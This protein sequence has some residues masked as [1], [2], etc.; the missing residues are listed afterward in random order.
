MIMYTN[1]NEFII[2]N[3]FREYFVEITLSKPYMEKKQNFNV[4][5]RYPES[6][7]F[8][9]IPLK[10]FS[11]QI[12]FNYYVKYKHNLKVYIG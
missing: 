11:Q 8:N 9:I 10:S 4:Y 3:K 5:R 6:E 2:L 12:F 7:I 1:K